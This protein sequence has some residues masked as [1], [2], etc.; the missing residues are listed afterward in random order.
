M[1]K[2]NKGEKNMQTQDIKT[3]PFLDAVHLRYGMYAGTEP[4][5][6]II[7]EI[8]SNALDEAK[9]GFGSLIQI[10]LDTATNTLTVRDFGRGI[11]P[12]KMLDVLTVP[13]TGGKFDESQGTAGLNG[14]GVKIATALGVVTLETYNGKTKCCLRDLH[15]SNYKTIQV[16]ECSSNRPRGTGF[17]FTPLSDSRFNTT[18]K[19]EDIINLIEDYIFC[20]D[21]TFELNIDGAISVYKPQK[22]TALMPDI[23][24]T[25]IFTS[26]AENSTTKVEIAMCWGDE[27]IDHCFING[28]RIEGGSHITTIRSAL[29]R[30]I[31]KFIDA[32]GDDIRRGLN[33]AVKVDTTEELFFSSQA[34]DKIAMPSINPVVSEA[35]SAITDTFTEKNL[36]N[37]LTRLRKIVKALD[38][39]KLVSELKNKKVDVKKF[40]KSERNGELFLIEGLSAGGGLNLVKNHSYQAS[41]AL[42][43]KLLNTWGKS[44]EEVK[45]NQEIQDLV[46]ILSEGWDKIILLTDA[47]AD[48]THI[49][50]LVVCFIHNFFPQYL[51]KGKI[52]T[53]E[54]PTMMGVDSKGNIVGFSGDAPIGLKEIEYLKG[55][56]QMESEL[57]R[58]YSVDKT[59]KLNQISYQNISV[60]ELELAFS[61]ALANERQELL[62]EDYDR[63]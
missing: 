22:L 60:E 17:T 10:K 6:H 19:K 40:N 43:G 18:I 20:N 24:Y 35:F 13:H 29:T 39:T 57:L 58:Y 51:E 26:T 54:L 44:L 50:L 42:R 63:R 52:Y 12:N 16:E 59:R 23:K 30:I 21:V 34:K 45:N 49:A 48:G 7:K 56:G 8:I 5:P 37:I 27:S 36:K 31:G 15:R 11:P 33:L 25:E 46:K 14:I 38:T 2:Q 32:K 53:V 3:L 28:V 61:K 55:L 41:Y 47:D 62:L 9:L 1:Y 4:I